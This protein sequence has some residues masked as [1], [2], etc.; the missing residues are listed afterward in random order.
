MIIVTGN[1]N[2]IMGQMTEMHQRKETACV[3]CK[4]LAFL[5]LIYV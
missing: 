2:A 3:S 5:L 4:S 1:F